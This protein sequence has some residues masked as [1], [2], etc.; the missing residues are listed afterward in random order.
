MSKIKFCKYNE[1]TTQGYA[2]VINSSECKNRTEFLQ[3]IWK[4]LMLPDKCNNS[5]NA[6]LDWMRDLDNLRKNTSRTFPF[7]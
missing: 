7:M 2:D 6:Y 5:W 3:D 1:Y 4:K